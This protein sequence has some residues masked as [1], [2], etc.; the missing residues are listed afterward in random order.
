M[1]SN[2]PTWLV[3]E[4]VILAKAALSY[5][6]DAISYVGSD[7]VLLNIG[8]QAR[9]LPCICREETSEREPGLACPP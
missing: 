8:R 1:G 4:K 6:G 2:M 5:R 3:E 9:K 7:V